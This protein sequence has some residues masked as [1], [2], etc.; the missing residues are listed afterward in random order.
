MIDCDFLQEEDE[1]K[2]SKQQIKF[3]CESL[4]YNNASFSLSHTDSDWMDDVYGRTTML[5]KPALVFQTL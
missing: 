5:E 2:I 4:S 1:K 3:L